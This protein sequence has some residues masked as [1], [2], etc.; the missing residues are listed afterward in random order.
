[1]RISRHDEIN[2][3]NIKMSLSKETAMQDYANRFRILIKSSQLAAALN[4][5]YIPC[6]SYL[7]SLYNKR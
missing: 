3:T 6:S 4:F 2:S 1:M 5:P 7:M